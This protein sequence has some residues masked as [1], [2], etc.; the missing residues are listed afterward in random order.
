MNSLSET[1]IFLFFRLFLPAS[2]S[3]PLKTRLY[4]QTNSERQWHYRFRHGQHFCRV[5]R[6]WD[7]SQAWNRLRG[8]EKV[9]ETEKEIFFLCIVG[10]CDTQFVCRIYALSSS[11]S[12]PLPQESVWFLCVFVQDCV[13]LHLCMCFWQV[14]KVA[15]ENIH[16]LRETQRERQGNRW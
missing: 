11:A 1:H 12:I 5:C 3:L 2:L 15:L 13:C 7:I 9:G 8:S 4:E 14:R 6:L 10:L 16:W